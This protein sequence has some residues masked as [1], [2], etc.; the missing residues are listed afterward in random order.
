MCR[1]KRH[2]EALPPAAAAAAASSVE[3]ALG[4]PVIQPFISK[5]TLT[6]RAAAARALL[7][8]MSATRLW[9]P[10]DEAAQLH[11]SAS[12]RVDVLQK[13]VEEEKREPG[14]AAPKRHRGKGQSPAEEF[15]LATL[16][17]WATT[18]QQCRREV[19]DEGDLDP[20]EDEELQ[21]F[22]RASLAEFDSGSL[23]MRLGVTRLWK[24]VFAHLAEEKIPFCGKL[25]DELRKRITAAVQDASLDQ[26][27]ERL[28]RPTLE[29][30]EALAKDVS[31]GGGRE[32]L[33]ST[34]P[35]SEAASGVSG[36][37]AV[38]SL[39]SWLSK[40]DSTTAELCAVQLGTLRAALGSGSGA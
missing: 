19:E 4:L 18:L 36:A 17:L 27:S 37:G 24:H 1:R 15:L 28:R 7:E 2:E 26:R 16:D 40:V 23:F 21:S 34:L 5:G 32:L 6:D 9:S 39:E 20:P 3:V 38:M 11:A 14:E 10:L 25:N 30:A 22:F 13:E 31:T 8:V 35:S 33:R 29:L 12:Q